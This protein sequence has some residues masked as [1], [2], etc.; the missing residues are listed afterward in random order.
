MTENNTSAQRNL[1]PIEISSVVEEA[2]PTGE[3]S[4]QLA[5]IQEIS[6]KIP[7]DGA[8][9]IELVTFKDTAWQVVSKKNEFSIGDKCLY[10]EVDSLIP[11]PPKPWNLFLWEKDKKDLTRPVRLKTCRFRKAISQGFVVPLSS[12][13]E[14]PSSVKVGEDVT[15][16]LGIKK[17]DPQAKEERDMDNS[18]N[19]KT[20]MPQWLMD[21]ACFRYIY[22]KLNPKNKGNF[23]NWIAKTDEKRIMVC[24]RI[25]MEHFDESWYVTEKCDGSSLSAF[26]YLKRILGFKTIKFGVASRK[27]WLKKENDSGYWAIA[28][29][30][31]LKRKFGEYFGREFATCQG[32]L[33]GPSIQDNKYGL[34]ENELFVFNII[35]QYDKKNP[36]GKRMALNQM[37]DACRAMGLKTVPII[38]EN[39]IPSIDLGVDFCKDCEKPDIPTVVNALVKM[40]NGKSA[41]KDRLREGLV[42]RLNSDPS[43][44]F[45]VINPEFSLENDE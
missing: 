36:N 23:P 30:L 34:S 45:K 31:S 38:N 5:T 43:V 7:I 37:K 27:I 25:L 6:K 20:N 35:H 42:F 19:D 18:Q 39:F 17:Y 41:L 1:N 21:I 9:R 24:A 11:A 3:T 16:L 29:K 26:Q 14:I 32:E 15:S 28:K 40:S 4:R 44:S 13:P 10:I 2:L 33:C 22:F 8:D 12:I